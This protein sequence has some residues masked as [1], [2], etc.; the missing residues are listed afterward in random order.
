MALLYTKENSHQTSSTLKK[1]F[2]QEHCIGGEKLTSTPTRTEA[3]GSLWSTGR[4]RTQWG[5]IIKRNLVRY[6]S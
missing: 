6:Q 4:V 5:K 1:D 2:L 3:S